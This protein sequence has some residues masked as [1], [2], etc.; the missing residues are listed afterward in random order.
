M[1]GVPTV[2]TKIVR[3]RGDCAI[4]SLPQSQAEKA[5]LAKQGF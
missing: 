4:L 2:V 1:V 3:R 5:A